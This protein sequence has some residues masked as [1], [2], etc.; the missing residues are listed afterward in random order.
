[1]ALLKFLSFFQHVDVPKTTSPPKK[2]GAVA[3]EVAIQSL[4]PVSDRVSRL[5]SQGTPILGGMVQ[6]LDHKIADELEDVLIAKLANVMNLELARYFP[7]GEVFHHLGGL[8]YVLIFPQLDPDAASR[9]LRSCTHLLS[10]TV[11]RQSVELSSHVTDVFHLAQFDSRAISAEPGIPSETLFDQLSALSTAAAAQLAVERLAKLHRCHV[12]FYP[13]WN[14]RKLMTTFNRAVLDMTPA[15]QT[16]FGALAGLRDLEVAQLDI[17]LVLIKK[18]LSALTHQSK[19]QKY[20]LMLVAVSFATLH[21]EDAAAAYCQFL[22]SIP[23]Q[24]RPSLILE[25]VDIPLD[26]GAGQLAPIVSLLNRFIRLVVI[27]AGIDHPLL[28]SLREL[29]VW[30]VSLNLGSARGTDLKL[31]AKLGR[32]AAAAMEAGVNAIAHNVPAPGLAL[33]AANA[34]IGFIDGPGLQASVK[35]PILPTKVAMPSRL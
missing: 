26:F 33:A 1:M 12:L 3:L 11:K 19:T 14:A 18:S 15:R 25:I 24:Y 7:R 22:A 2:A 30:A 10:E 23:S 6:L 4:D 9:R 35:L 8:R 21:D 5:A 13:A 28:S 29:N 16:S 20:P 32:F 31:P 34:G 17:D 27:E